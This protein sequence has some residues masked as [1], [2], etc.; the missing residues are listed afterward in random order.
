MTDPHLIV[1][2]GNSASGKTSLALRLQHALGRGTANIGQDHFRR[3][4][5]REHDVPGGTNIGF[6]DNAARYCLSAGWNVIVEGILLS[7][8]YGDML[9]AL[10]SSHQG[11]AH[12][13]YLAV[14]LDETIRRHEGRPLGVDV[15]SDKLR[16]WFCPD[17]LLGLPGE[18]V[19]D[20]S[21]SLGD[22]ERVLVDDV[23]RY[24]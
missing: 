13:Y 20:G 7:D 10:V 24:P 4:V 22:L 8:H 12:L 21:A 9:R 18:R 14:D 5:L 16:E 3:T 1:I 6:I 19:I 2:R 11:A 15:P 17:D 23:G